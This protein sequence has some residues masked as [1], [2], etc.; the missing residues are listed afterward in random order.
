MNRQAKNGKLYNG[1]NK[2]YLAIQALCIMTWL[3]EIYNVFGSQQIQFYSRLFLG[4]VIF[5]SSM[6][7]S[8]GILI[9][10]EKKLLLNPVFL[11]CSG[12]LLLLVFTIPADALQQ[13]GTVN[14]SLQR[15]MIDAL[16]AWVHLP[17]NIL[18]LTAILCI[19]PKPRYIIL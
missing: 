14:S 6:H 13:Y 1:Y 3:C 19:P 9:S 18:F 4:L 7:T 12:Y 17:V 15:N 16:L 10:H 2:L 5:V 11:V 8:S